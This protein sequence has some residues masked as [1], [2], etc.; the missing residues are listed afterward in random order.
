MKKIIVCLLAISCFAVFIGGCAASGTES[1]VSETSLQT[2]TTQ[3]TE[4]AVASPTDSASSTYIEESEAKTVAL[5]HAEVTESE[6]TYV[7]VKLDYD[8][9]RTVYDIEFYT[10][11][12]EYDY[13]IDA[14]TGDILSYDYDI[15]NYT[16]SSAPVDD[17]AYISLDKAKEI[18]LNK[19]NLTAEQ[20]TY[21]KESFEYDDGME[22]YQI[23]FISDGMEYEVEI[24]AADGTIIGYEAESQYD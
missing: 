9:G 3:T 4:L 8:D 18:A 23:D 5:E 6:V 19:A 11:N 13:E 10:G 7:N 15:D 1:D 20:I 12:T 24:N 22:V 16:V 21:T 17:S 2:D 14:Y